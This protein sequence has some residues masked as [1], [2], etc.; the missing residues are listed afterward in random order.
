[1]KLVF[2]V[3]SHLILAVIFGLI[4]LPVYS[5]TTEGKDKEILLTMW[6]ADIGSGFKKCKPVLWD[7]PVEKGGFS[8]AGHTGFGIYRTNVKIPLE[9]HGKQPALFFHGIDDADETFLNGMKIGATGSFPE[10]GS[11]GKGYISAWTSSRV[12]ILPESI[13]KYGAVNTVEVKVY[14]HSGKGGIYGPDYP[15]INLHRILEK[16]AFLLSMRRN[17]PRIFILSLFIFFI[18]LL[19]YKTAPYVRRPF[20][21]YIIRSLKKNFPS[22]LIMKRKR[23]NP[24]IVY[25]LPYQLAGGQIIM[26]F[27]LSLMFLFVLYELTIRD[28]PLIGTELLGVK[29]HI[30]VLYIGLFF[31]ILILHNDTFAGNHESKSRLLRLYTTIEDFLT[32]PLLFLIYI[33]YAFTRPSRILYNDF[34]ARGSYLLI[35]ILSVSAFRM[36]RQIHIKHAEYQNSKSDGRILM[37][38][39]NIML[40]AATAISLVFFITD[41]S[42]VNGQTTVLASLFFILYI[43]ATLSE[44]QKRLDLFLSAQET[45]NR[46]IRKHDFY[47]DKIELIKNF[48]RENCTSEIRRDD[49]AAE[50]EMSPEHLSRVFNMITGGTIVDFI[51]SARIEKS[52]TLLKD[53]DKTIIEIGFDSGFSSP[54]TFNRTFL[55]H[56]KT[57]PSEFRKKQF[58]KTLDK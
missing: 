49:I 7:T 30:P 18:I 23:P 53:T 26:I 14:N 2:I 27:A 13:I 40:I 33:S 19:I 35:T 48:I 46:N 54:S 28:F 41:S 21:N 5:E 51:N 39:L 37:T 31:I 52:V 36:I 25:N 43:N 10:P 50:A 57:S 16:K 24:E 45:E 9:F 17:A 3:I 56:M 42:S 58:E 32:N 55:K 11:D 34:S 29:Y 12:Y 22:M 4:I 20:F 44:N 8:A 15:E 1:M 38:A 47:K 6:E